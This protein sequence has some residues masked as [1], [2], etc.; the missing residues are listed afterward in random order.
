MPTTPAIADEMKD[1]SGV[2]F[3]GVEEFAKRASI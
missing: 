1:L 2:V 3:V